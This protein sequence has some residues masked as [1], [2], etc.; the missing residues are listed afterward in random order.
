MTIPVFLIEFSMKQL[1]IL[2]FVGRF[3][4]RISVKNWQIGILNYFKTNWLY[5]R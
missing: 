2:I 3:V 4:I 5:N 1:L